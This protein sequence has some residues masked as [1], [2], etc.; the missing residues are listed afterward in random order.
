MNMGQPQ[1]NN[2]PTGIFEANG[3]GLD[4]PGSYSLTAAVIFNG[5]RLYATHDFV[6]YPHPSFEVG[7]V[8]PNRA[9]PLLLH[10]VIPFGE[11]GFI[12]I[13]SSYTCNDDIAEPFAYPP[14]PPLNGTAYNDTTHA[15]HQGDPR[16]LLPVKNVLS[17]TGVAWLLY[18]S[19]L[20]FSSAENAFVCLQIERH[21]GLFVPLW[22][23]YEQRF[24][25]KVPVV[26][27]F[28]VDSPDQ[29]E[30]VTTEDAAAWKTA[31]T[32]Y[33]WAAIEVDVRYGC[34]LTPPMNGSLSPCT[35]PLGHIC[36]GHTVVQNGNAV[37]VGVCTCCEA[38]MLA[39]TYVSGA[40]VFVGVSYW[41]VVM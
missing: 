40:F 21:P 20:A 22:S 32:P 37:N 38:W 1:H 11:V 39:V 27:S 14:E 8:K 24:S 15:V 29:C 23:Y 34:M 30:R 36:E 4:R 7:V 2:L 31:A 16:T 3:L 26:F 33:Q 28:V 5:V 19:L 9:T 6:C 35:C 41:L 25:E 18:E 10:G 12:R 13:S 17:K